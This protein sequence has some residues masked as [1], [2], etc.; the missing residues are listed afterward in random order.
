MA[1]LSITV[2]EVTHGTDARCGIAQAGEALTACVPVYRKDSD[3]KVYKADADAENTADAIG[4]TVG[5]AA[6]DADV[7]YCWDGPLTVGAS[8]S[9]TAGQTYCVSTNVGKIAVESDLTTG[10]YVTH[11]GVG[12][13]SNQIEV[14]I[15]ASGI[16]H[17]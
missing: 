3:G 14:H 4:I 8:A 7:I 1:D 10:D 6:A 9:V 17:A 12:N 5:S 16:S 11:L 13:A 15:H 2:S